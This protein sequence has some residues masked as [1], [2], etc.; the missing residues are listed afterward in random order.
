MAGCVSEWRACKDYIDCGLE[1][2]IVGKRAVVAVQSTIGC[3]ALAAACNIGRG[4]AGA[5]VRMVLW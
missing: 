1:G 5:C 2:L 3:R 4:L